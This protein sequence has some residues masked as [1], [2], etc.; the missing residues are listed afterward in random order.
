MFPNCTVVSAKNLKG[1]HIRAAHKGYRTPH[2]TRRA[3]PRWSALRGAGGSETHAA[4]CARQGAQTRTQLSAKTILSRL[5][6]RDLICISL[7]SVLKLLKVIVQKWDRVADRIRRPTRAPN[8]ST[9]TS[10]DIAHGLPKIS[11]TQFGPR[12][13]STV[14]EPHSVPISVPQFGWNSVPHSVP[15]LFTHGTW[16]PQGQKS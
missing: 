11:V 2:A 12:F 5:D 10:D 8:P 7:V 13:W 14:S 3:Q 15:R 1:S 6:C 4:R 16:T 9:N